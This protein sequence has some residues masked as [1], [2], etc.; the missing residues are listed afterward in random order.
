MF[1][2][3]SQSSVGPHPAPPSLGPLVD[4]QRGLAEDPVLVLLGE[5]RDQLGHNQ[6]LKPVAWPRA[7]EFQS[8]RR[9][10]PLSSII[11]FA[12]LYTKSTKRHLC[13]SSAH[14]YSC[15]RSSA[16][17]RTRR[18]PCALRHAGQHARRHSRCGTGTC[19]QKERKITSHSTS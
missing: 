9:R 15:R 18:R 14:G 11:L 3:C 13:D 5:E 12:I 4:T 1:S 16:A 6:V 19:G 2:G 8:F 10:G 17:A 7:A